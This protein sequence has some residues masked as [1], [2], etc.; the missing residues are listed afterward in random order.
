[1]SAFLPQQDPNPRKRAKKLKDAQ[2]IYNYCYT[3]VSPLAVADYVPIHDEFSFS[4]IRT[5][6]GKVLNAL[7]NRAEVELDIERRDHHLSKLSWFRKCVE[8]GEAEICNLKHLV[9]EALR[10]EMRAGAHGTRPQ[11]LED[12]AELFHTIGLPPVAH[13][14]QADWAF[15][16]QRLAGPNPVMLKKMPEPLDNFPVTDADFAVA[17]PNDTLQ[18]AM[19]E[20]RLFLCDYAILDGAELGSFPHGQKYVYAPL[21]MFVVDA[22]S[23]RLTPVAIQC[24]QK[25]AKT[26]PIFTP[27]D[28]YNWLIAKTIVEVADGNVHEAF[29]HLGRTHLLMEP[30]VVS[31][32]RH[33]APRHPLGI[34]FKPHFEGTLAINEAAWGHLIANKG[35]V[36]KL[37]GGSIKTS[38]GAAVAGVQTAEV[39]KL[40]L[41]NTFVERG[42]DDV[43]IL[44][45]YP[46]RDDASMYWSAIDKWVS[47]YVRLYYENDAAVQQDEEVQAWGKEIA[48]KDGGRINGMPDSG[49]IQSVDDLIAVVTLVVYTCSVQHA[50]VNFPQ[51]D[52]MSY[53]PNM[54]LALYTPAPTTKHGA[55]EADYLNALPPMDMAELQMELGFLLGTVHYTQLGQYERHHFRDQRVAEPLAQFQHDLSSIGGKIEHRNQQRPRAYETLTP[56]GIPQSINI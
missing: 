18:A 12:Y 25:P 13:D 10:F 1:M 8:I 47:A 46:Y 20:G 23:G 42:V 28:G 51:Y 15:A 34:L 5:V 4:W 49:A 40:A 56:V 55:T 21:A 39:T 7:A 48:S 52:M 22:A 9:A 36:D 54:P 19:S 38:R 50:A 26:N 16:Y 2:G 41:P 37:F 35:A 32:L 29:T 14:Y 53:V 44:N 24:K 43:E 27:E 6:G 30:F 11:S 3:H 31:T 17:A 45:D 33:I